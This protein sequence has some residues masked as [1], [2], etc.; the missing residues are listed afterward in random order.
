MS[1]GYWDYKDS[2]L[3]SEIFGWSWSDDAPIKNVFEDKEISILVYDVFG[4]MHDFDWYK[5]GDT[6]E[7]T[8]LKKKN[9]FKKK[10]FKRGRKDIC[11]N[12]VDSSI[13]ELRKE[14]YKTFLGEEK[15]NE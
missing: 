7:E 5:S 2:S 13:E 1:G 10:W 11:K 14:L 3:K 8:W 15:V 12:I 9:E 6:C 4:L